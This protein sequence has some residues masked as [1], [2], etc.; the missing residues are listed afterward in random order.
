[1]SNRNPPFGKIPLGD[2]ICKKCTLDSDCL[3]RHVVSCSERQLW[4]AFYC[5]DCGAKG[6]VNVSVQFRNAQ[7]YCW[8]ERSPIAQMARKQADNQDMDSA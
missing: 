4:E 5:S 6:L 2:K 7:I 8:D 3:S 1:M